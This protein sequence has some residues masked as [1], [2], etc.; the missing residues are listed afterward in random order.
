MPIKTE[1]F[2]YQAKGIRSMLKLGARVL[3]ADEMGLGKTVSSLG[4]ADATQDRYDRRPVVIICPA[5]VKYNWQREIKTHLGRPSVVLE[6]RRSS[7]VPAS[8][9]Y[10]VNYQILGDPKKKKSWARYLKQLNPWL[11]IIDECQAIKSRTTL[12]YQNVQAFCKPI[13]HLVALSGTPLVNRPSELW[14][15]LNL[16]RPD[17]WPKFFQFAVKHCNPEKKPWGW[18]YKGAERLDELHEDLLMWCMVRRLK[19]DV[20]TDLPAKV[21]AVETLPIANPKQYAAAVAD[22][23][24][25]LRTNFKGKATKAK[26]AE[27]LVKTGYLLRLAA[28]LKLPAVIEWIRL[29][30][31]DNPGKL[32]VFGLHKFVLKAIK[33]AFPG[34][35]V[36][37]DGSVTARKRQDAFDAFTKDP[38]CRL[39]AG[40]LVAAGAGWNGTAASAV[41]FVEL[42]WRPGLHKQGEDRIHR[43][44][45][46]G[47]AFIHYLVGHGTIEERMCQI[48]EAKQKV[49]DATLDGGEVLDSLNV[50]SELSAEL[51]KQAGVPN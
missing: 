34:I 28:E 47:T 11:V 33:D 22:F 36:H 40:N 31:E 51:S 38:K 25:W 19:E 18:E 35:T 24:R 27:K 48:L 7:K 45:Q 49:I 50:Y 30:L 9:F 41:A 39:L 37:V 26:R 5:V 6:H 23:L 4:Y 32:I 12:T 43:I 16:L 1:L 17:K 20:L 10:I 14:P 3:L 13:P 46:T 21:R 15:V 2:K 29:W 44:G 8:R 42:D